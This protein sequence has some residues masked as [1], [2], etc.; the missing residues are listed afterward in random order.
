MP[1]PEWDVKPGPKT[2]DEL[3]P[4]ISSENP[5]AAGR[6]EVEQSEDNV[7]GEPLNLPM[8]MFVADLPAR[9]VIYRFKVKGRTT[10]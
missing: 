8:E 6:E 10:T 2:R 7:F 3:Q 1:L 5:V 9:R 4:I